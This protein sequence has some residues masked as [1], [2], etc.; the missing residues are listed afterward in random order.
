M[1]SVMDHYEKLER[2][3]LAYV[4]VFA[5]DETEQDETLTAIH[6]ALEAGQALADAAR[7]TSAL[8]KLKATKGPEQRMLDILVGK[9]G[10]AMTAEGDAYD[11]LLDAYPGAG[12]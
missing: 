10:D 8:E 11:A 5:M 9:F 4:P 3:V 1:K 2:M 12:Q 6:T 7:L